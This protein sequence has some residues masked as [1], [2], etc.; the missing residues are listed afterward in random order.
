M[1]RFHD[2]TY[3]VHALFERRH[4]GTLIGGSASI[5]PAKNA[6]LAISSRTVGPDGSARFSMRR[7]ATPSATP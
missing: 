1:D 4:I 3:V 2:S 5:R 6:E 7:W